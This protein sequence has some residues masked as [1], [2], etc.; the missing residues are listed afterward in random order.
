MHYLEQIQFLRAPQSVIVAIEVAE[1][2][3]KNA[4]ILRRQLLLRLVVERRRRKGDRAL[5]DVEDLTD[6]LPAAR[7]A[8][9][10]AL[11]V[12]FHYSCFHFPLNTSRV[13]AKHA[14]GDAC[15][16]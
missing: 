3:A 9:D 4:L 14:R 8:L 11:D 6:V 15:F 12:L 1:D 7:T 13:D 2:A 16:G 10:A 5:R